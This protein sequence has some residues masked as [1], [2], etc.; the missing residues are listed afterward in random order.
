VVAAAHAGW[1]GLAGQDGHGILDSTVRALREQVSPQAELMAWLGPCIG[2][3]AF[4]VGPEVVDAFVANGFHPHGLS[5]P[6]PGQAG[7]WLLD[8]AG[9]ARQRLQQLGVTTLAGNDGHAGWCTV[10]DT[11]RWF[12]H[13]R[14]RVSGRLAALIW[15]T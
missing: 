1:R 4:E 8:L 15:R 9:L 11:A 7:K 13:R 14:D 10:T 5:R 3:Q 6:H 2:P 12:S